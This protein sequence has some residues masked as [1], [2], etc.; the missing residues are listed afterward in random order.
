MLNFSSFKMLPQPVTGGR[1]FAAHHQILD[2]LKLHP[3]GTHGQQL[4]PLSSRAGEHLLSR[5][6]LP[7]IS[8]LTGN[9]AAVHWFFQNSSGFQLG[10]E[11][12]WRDIW[13][14]LSPA[15]PQPLEMVTGLQHGHHQHEAKLLAH[16]SQLTRAGPWKETPSAQRC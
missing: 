5:V 10:N 13:G 3:Q 14:G 4:L 12:A 16:R 1:L 15:P 8:V 7:N 9:L 2:L 6:P 11:L